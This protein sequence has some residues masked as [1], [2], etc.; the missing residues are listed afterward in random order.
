MAEREGFEPSIRLTVYRF[1]RPA[2]SSALPP[3]RTQARIYLFGVVFK[4]VVDKVYRRLEIDRG[5]QLTAILR[6]S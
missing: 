4:L 6:K 3:L 2:H 1:S 5:C